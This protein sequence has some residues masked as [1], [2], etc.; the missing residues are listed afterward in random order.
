MLGFHLEDNHLER[1]FDFSGESVLGNIYCGYVKDIATNIN[2]AFVEFDSGKKGYLSLKN[3]KG[4]IKQGERVLVQVSADKIKSKDYTLTGKI[5]L[6]SECLVL[7]V[8]NTDIS[9]SKKINDTEKRDELKQTLSMFANEEYGFILR[10]NSVY[11]SKEDISNQAQKLIERWEEIKNKFKYAALK[12]A[13]VKNNYMIS[14]CT[15]F[16]EKFKGDLFTDSIDVFG[17]I[18]A[19]GLP[20]LFNDDSKISL[21]NK[22]SLEK[23]LR[24]ALGKKVWLKSG[25]YLV[26]EP[27]EALTVIDVNTGKAEVKTER[28]KTFKKINI[29]AAIEIARQIRVRN[30]SGIIIIDFI[31]MK[32]NESYVE[33]EQIFS[34][35]IKCD[36]SQCN[37]AGFTKLGLL[38]ISRKKQEKPLHE[39]L[40]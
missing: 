17:E 20:I 21:C 9:V 5:N 10:T 39:I 23:H 40:N 31:N 36:F 7:T 4:K 15:E 33:L 14:M 32:D 30:L 37:I 34:N 27:T 1:I 38:E 2:A 12:T 16:V 11:F 3:Y 8:G 26:V 22:Y 18:K 24:E 35:A 25:A 29:E 19:A 6:N 13:I 28:E